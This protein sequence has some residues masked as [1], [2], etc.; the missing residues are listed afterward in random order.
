MY[1]HHV[2]RGELTWYVIGW[3]IPRRNSHSI[4]FVNCSDRQVQIGAFLDNIVNIVS[5]VS[6]WGIPRRDNV[7]KN[8]QG[9]SIAFVKCSDVG[10]AGT[11]QWVFFTM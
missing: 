10:E 4:A 2:R 6:G 8:S 11:D 7:F 1:T 9:H 3:G 5:I